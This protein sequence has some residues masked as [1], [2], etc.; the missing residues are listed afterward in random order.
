M[1]DLEALT[2][3]TQSKA[4]AINDRGQ[5]LGT[6]NNETVVLWETGSR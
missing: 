6:T 5:V 1:T 3:S 4:V 2:G